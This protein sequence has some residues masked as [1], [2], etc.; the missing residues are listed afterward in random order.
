[1]RSITKGVLFICVSAVVLVVVG[2]I[3]FIGHSMFPEKSVTD[4]SRYEEL[5][6]SKSSVP[7]AVTDHFPKVI[8]VNGRNVRLDYFPKILQGG[9][10][11]QLRVQLP[12]KEMD[13]ILAKYEGLATLRFIG[14][15]RYDHM[16]QQPEGGHTTDFYTGDTSNRKFTDS[17]EI[18]VLGGKYGNHG[19]SHG[20]AVDR[21]SSDVV[22]WA[23][24]W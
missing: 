19:R 12:R 17:F 7:L 10:H 21:S 13:Q 14:G 24:W 3:A 6:N 5:L 18:L 8:P 20:L 2:T 1:M 23:E 15:N 11:L 4:I 9:G 16:R 22:F